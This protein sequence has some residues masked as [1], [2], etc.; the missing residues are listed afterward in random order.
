MVLQGHKNSFKITESDTTLCGLLNSQCPET[1]V[2]SQL[3]QLCPFSS[4]HQLSLSTFSLLHYSYRIS[5]SAIAKGTLILYIEEKIYKKHDTTAH[6]PS[7]EV[8]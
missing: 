8:F 2:I 3:S 6:K 4:S 7:D 1:V 5:V